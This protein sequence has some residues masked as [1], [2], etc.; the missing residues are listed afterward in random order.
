VSSLKPAR[1]EIWWVDLEPTL[2]R[3]QRGT[4]P[5][6][7]LSANK[8]NHGPAE[9]VILCPI[10]KV[11][12][13][14]PSHVGITPEDSGLDHESHIICEQVRCVSKQRLRERI[15]QASPPVMER[16]SVLLRVLLEI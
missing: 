1:G 16:V 10:T 3:E 12:K 5:A 8:F 4:R 15:G 11:S 9:L 7:V 14:I 13:G 2:G 6:L